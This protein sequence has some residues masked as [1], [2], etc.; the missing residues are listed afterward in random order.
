MTS[1]EQRL[2]GSRLAAAKEA[3]IVLGLGIA[4]LWLIP[5]QTTSGPVLGLPPAFLPTL[6]AAAII[7]LASLGLATRLWKPEPLRTERTAPYWPAGLLL[8]IAVAGVLALQFVSSFVCGLLIIALGLPALGERR[9]RV[10][11][12][13]LGVAALVLGVVLRVWR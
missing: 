4:A 1:D 5:A 7:A 13:T 10:F 3:A 11:L 9:P 8:C 12:P 2:N 6:C